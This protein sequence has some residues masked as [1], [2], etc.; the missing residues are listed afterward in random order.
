MGNIVLLDELTINKIA[1]GEVIERPASV[2]KEM[3]ENSID[4]GAS[5]I[6]VEIKNGGISFIRI[7]DNGKG[8]AEDD[9]EIAFERH[10][11]SK[12]RV[13]DDILKVTSMGFRGE[14]LASIAAIANVEMISRTADSSIG[15][16]IVVEGGQVLEQSEVGAP[17]GTTITVK[18]LFYNTPVRYKFLKKD[19]TESGY[20]EDAISRL[21]LVNKDISFKLI[22]SG[23]TVIQTNGNNDEKS[24]I[25]SIFGKDIAGA[26]VNVEHEYEGIKVSGVVGKPEIARSN[27]SNQLFF[28]N[29]R[30]VKDR[31]LTAAAEQA[32]KTEIPVN[33][34][35]FL[36]LNI[37]IDPS[38]V[39]VNVHPA[40]LEVRFEDENKVFK[41]AYGAIKEALSKKEE[42][43][44]DEVKLRSTEEVAVED[45]KVLKDLKEQSDE[46]AKAIKEDEK[47]EK[48][49]RIPFF[50]KG[51][52]E[53]EPEN[54]KENLLEEVYKFRKGL[55]EIGVSET[56]SSVY[57]PIYDL[58]ES[59]EKG[60]FFTSNEENVENNRTNQGKIVD[61]S[62]EEKNDQVKQEKEAIVVVPSE[63]KV[64]EMTEELIKQRE[65]N[66]ILEEAIKN[67]KLENP[68]SNDDI[69][70]ENDKK[71]DDMYAKIFGDKPVTNQEEN[72]EKILSDS[73]RKVL[74]EIK[75]SVRPVQVDD[76]KENE[77][78]I[79][80]DVTDITYMGNVSN[81][82][83]ISGE[84]NISNNEEV[85]ENKVNDNQTK[86]EKNTDNVQESLVL[87]NDTNRLEEF[88]NIASKNY[89]FVGVAFSNYIIVE[90]DDEM[91]VIDWKA[92]N[93]KIMYENIKNNYYS[94]GDKD[95]QIMLMADI[96]TLNHRQTEL[97][98]ENLEMFENAGFSLE[99]FGE[100]TIKLN[101]VPN[102][103]IDMNTKHLFLEL[104]DGIDNYPK[105]GSQAKENMFMSDI[106]RK[107][108]VA[109]NVKLTDREV[110][111]VLKKL[112]E[113]ENPYDSPDGKT[114]AVEMSKYDIER[115]FSRK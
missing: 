50:K 78:A 43:K 76:T 47:N 94:D 109:L 92:A 97:I 55:E 13:A 10:A 4:A 40:K 90:I 106:A 3:V 75:N 30:F 23:K 87:E 110:D 49:N 41:A 29:G 32:F 11:T 27:R 26:V 96:I 115:K 15:H 88:K 54:E 1:A 112:L 6:T 81:D 42:S 64:Q 69:D 45:E 38:L 83:E 67:S 48:K 46:V 91:C 24:V 51:R 58:E 113:F 107:T 59:V 28:V 98:K 18:N 33:K 86:E 37:E 56:P 39:D 114:I 7:S 17:I 25:Y 95:S 60:G 74:D 12:I 44:I 14:A 102:I 103:C 19:Y 99:A 100:N 9:M 85:T 34:Y 108:A 84:E 65:S 72:E 36:V 53:V 57:A 2:V 77:E 5:K 8:I 35:G 61:T 52:R 66:E 68:F 111:R 20:I 70:T 93:E 89:K 31:T 73:E 22:N 79:V 16:R 80:A 82:E 101:G 104:L 21:A 105:N 63:D 62:L 71:F